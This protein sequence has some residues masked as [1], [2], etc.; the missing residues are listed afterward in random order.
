MFERVIR[1]GVDA[2]VMYVFMYVY[3]QF[4]FDCMW[5]DVHR[6][7]GYVCTYEYGFVHV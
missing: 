1:Q 3:I 5:E 2:C 7:C 4:G 6:V